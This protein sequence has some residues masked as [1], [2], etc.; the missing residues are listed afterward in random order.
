MEVL[1]LVDLTS[2]AR[3]LVGDPL[4]PGGG[5]GLSGEQRKRLTIAVE[6]VAQPRWVTREVAHSCCRGRFAGHRTLACRLR[7]IVLLWLLPAGCADV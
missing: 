5:T 2:Q 4:G 1:D 7:I 6:L 3:S